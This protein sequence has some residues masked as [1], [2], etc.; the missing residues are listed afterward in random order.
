MPNGVQFDLQQVANKVFEAI[1]TA[2]V[3]TSGEEARENNFLS[4]ADGISVNGDHLL[5]DAKQAVLALHEKGYKAR[6]KKK[7][8]V[9]GETG[10]ATLLLGAEAMKLSG[11]ISEHDLKIAKKVAY[12]IAGGKVPYGTEVD[13]EYL[14]DLER[15]AF[16]SL[17]K[18][19]KTQQRMQHMLVKGK[20]LRN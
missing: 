5:Y 18:E 17:I 14:L 15:E 16:L 6:V 8:P 13:E 10:Y 3:S 9:V 7:V 2:K 12:V 4:K 20:P 1:A 11:Y 19:P